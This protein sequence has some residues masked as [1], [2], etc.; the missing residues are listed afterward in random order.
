M[1]YRYALLLVFFISL[2]SFTSLYST[3]DDDNNIN[4]NATTIESPE[5]VQF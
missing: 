3:D 2:P 5:D 4:T 1:L